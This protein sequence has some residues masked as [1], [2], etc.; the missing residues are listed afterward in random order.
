MLWIGSSPDCLREEGSEVVLHGDMS[1]EDRS[2]WIGLAWS[3]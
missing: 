2:G 3:M 1:T